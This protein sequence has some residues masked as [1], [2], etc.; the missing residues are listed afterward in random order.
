M[1]DRL[2]EKARP[3]RS[4][5]SEANDADP[6]ARHASAEQKIA[7]VNELIRYVLLM[8]RGAGRATFEERIAVRLDVNL[9][10]LRDAIAARERSISISKADAAA[11]GSAP[12]R[13]RRR[14]ATRG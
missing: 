13:H 14:Q 7:A 4:D 6:A 8:P 11:G 1:G 5:G 10:A 9:R 2:P 12:P 3:D